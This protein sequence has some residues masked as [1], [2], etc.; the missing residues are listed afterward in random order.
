MTENT[1]AKLFEHN[2]W[3]N[4]QII[5]TCSALGDDQLDARRMCRRHRFKL[6]G[7]GF[8][9]LVEHLPSLGDAFATGQQAMVA[10]DHGLPRRALGPRYAWPP[11]RP[12][13]P[14]LRGSPD[15]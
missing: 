4:R 14:I 1:L 8:L 15:P 5:R 7:A 13:P 10:Q 9:E 6:R 11:N 2:N 3:A 12:G